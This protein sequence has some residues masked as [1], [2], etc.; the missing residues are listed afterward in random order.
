M[1]FKLFR[2]NA[3]L[4]DDKGTVALLM[5]VSAIP[6][7]L[8]AGIALDTNRVVNAEASLQNL[9]DAAALTGAAT[10]GTDEQ[11]KLQAEKYLSQTKIN[12]YGVAYSWQIKIENKTINV[13]IKSSV[14]GTLTK[15]G[16][17]RGSATGM[18][19]LA[20]ASWNTTP[21]YDACIVATDRRADGAIRLSEA[22]TL[23]ADSC[24]IHAN[25]TD[26]EA[27]R[28]E[29][30]KTVEAEGIHTRGN[31]LNLVGGLYVDAPWSRTMAEITENPVPHYNS[32]SSSDITITNNATLSDRTYDDIRIESGTATLTPGVHYVKGDIEIG[33]QGTLKG[34]GVTIVLLDDE[35][36]IRTEAGSNL[37]LRAP[38]KQELI[39]AGASAEELKLAG[40]AIAASNSH[41]DDDYDDDR[42]LL[43]LGAG[44]SIRGG[45]YMPG[46]RLRLETT[47]GFNAGSVYTPI[48]ARRVDIRNSGN[49]TIGFDYAAYGF[50][51]PEWLTVPDTSEVRLVK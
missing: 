7:F 35:A 6:I 20:R 38:T 16:L 27:V 31:T 13:A 49:L 15:V 24:V 22:G 21:A 43:R 14:K 2:S 46:R 48:L 23:T 12:I 39:D 3:F 29:T 42:T 37:D 44:S 26:N 30:A 8:A 4:R 47:S 45:I 18:S 19:T 41:H 36:R 11:K 34:E 1:A 32:G 50:E 40:I 33:S 5:G 25:S 17:G 10:H 9:A 28:V 51:R